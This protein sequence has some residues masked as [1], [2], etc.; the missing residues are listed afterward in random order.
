MARKINRSFYYIVFVLNISAVIAQGEKCGTFRQVERHWKNRTY[1]MEQISVPRP[2]MQKNILTASKKFRIHFDTTG[3]NE[4]AMVDV[5]GNRIANS[6]Q[7]FVDTLSSI[8]DSVW[9]AEIDSYNFIAPPADSG[10]GGGDEYDFYIY[11]LP[12]GS[13]GETKIEDDLPV[14]PTKVNQQFAT[15]IEMDNDFGVG[16]RTKGVQAIMATAAHEFHHAVQVGGSGVWEGE[17]FYFYELCAEAMEN[18]V[19]KDAKDY[20]FDVKTY[21]TNISSTPLFQQSLGLSTAGYERAIWGIFLM[22]KYG[23]GIMKEI[24]NEMKTNR[25]IPALKNTLSLHLSTIE[26]EFPLFSLWN[27]YTNYR[28]D[29]SK[30]FLDAKLFP[31]VNFSESVSLTNAEVVIQKTS[32]SFATN[33]IR[34]GHELDTAFIIIANTNLI[35]AESNSGQSFPFQLQVSPFP[36]ANLSKISNSIYAKFAVNDL[37]NWNYALSTDTT[38]IQ[39]PSNFDFVSVFPNPFKANGNNLLFMSINEN[40]TEKSNV[41]MHVFSSTSDLIFSGEPQFANIFGK[42]FAVWNGKDNNG[43]MVPS[44]IYLYLLT[45]ESQVIKGKFAV[46]R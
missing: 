4:P 12:P 46:I 26:K 27:F 20:I 32:R 37:Q 22:K 2:A 16:Y 38:G 40:S 30:Y 14:G 8:L 10:R 19:F 31:A 13:F 42:R 24:W 7:Q 23:N 41:E 17:H 18:T 15:F 33:F 6:Y 3:V 21:F 9:S 28:A 43:N 35:D 39:K 36:N 45:K 44:G 5:S 25:P 1:K 29:S 34:V 11:D